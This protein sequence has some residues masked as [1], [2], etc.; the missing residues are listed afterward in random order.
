MR[1][2]I[3]V[4]CLMPSVCA[5]AQFN[6]DLF[7]TLNGN[8]FIPVESADR[9]FPIVGFNK[10]LKPKLLI[11]GFGV[12]FAG[13]KM[14]SGKFSLKTQGTFFRKAYWQQ[15]LFRRGPLLSD[16]VGEATVSTFDYTMGAAAIPH[17]HFSRAFSVGVGVGLHA[18]LFSNSYLRQD[19]TA[20]GNRNLG[21]NRYYKSFMPIVP[22]ETSLR[23]SRWA[24]NV[25]YE[26][27]LLNRFKGNLADYK[28]E[29][30]G[31]LFFELGYKI[32]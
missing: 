2:I 24:V 23:L 7:I 6:P 9:M 8:L 1:A 10:E 27:A 30:Y 3:F 12:G 17:F 4:L 15:Y 29:K 11:G 31:L 14:I 16:I 5:F 21:R 22:F 28:K 20:D 26:H 19:L 25:R 18:L 13:Q 32:N